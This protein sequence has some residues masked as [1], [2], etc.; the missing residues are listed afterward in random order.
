MEMFNLAVLLNNQGVNLLT[1]TNKAAYEMETAMMDVEE[2]NDDQYTCH[3]IQNDNRMAA[4]TI[5]TLDLDR[6]T[7]FFERALAL[8]VRSAEVY[9]NEGGLQYFEPDEHGM[10]QFEHD[11]I[12][13]Q[14]I[15]SLNLQDTGVRM[16]GID[17]ETFIHWKAVKIGNDD[18]VREE[19]A[20]FVNESIH[21]GQEYRHLS[22]AIFHSMICIYNLGLCY[23]YKGIQT[24]SR[25]LLEAAVDHYMQAYEL[26]TRFRLQHIDQYTLLMATMNNLATTYSFLNEPE[27]RDVCNNYL[28][29]T[30]MLL[31]TSEEGQ[32]NHRE[33]THSKCTQSRAR[34][35]TYQSFLSNVMYLISP[36]DTVASAA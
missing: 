2:T 5:N 31:T 25:S 9:K 32:E 1:K 36:Q 24:S 33:A 15:G 19:N 7:A 35:T 26:A 28:L 13:A 30:L 4:T 20:T 18:Y 12:G 16:N 11:H 29:S 23:Q 10:I 34:Q 8:I 14:L 6:A 17:D 3:N 22:V 21:N 27:R